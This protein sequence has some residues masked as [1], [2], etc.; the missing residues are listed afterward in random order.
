MDDPVVI[1]DFYD[2]NTLEFLQKE[3]ASPKWE[4]G[5]RSVPETQFPV[6][7]KDILCRRHHK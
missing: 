6:V 2:S 1:D 3:V 4:F 5:Q 7:S